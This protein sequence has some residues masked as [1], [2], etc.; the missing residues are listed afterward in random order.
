MALLLGVL[1]V[2]LMRTGGVGL[3]TVLGLA[4]G[5][6]VLA[7][8]GLVLGLW[9]LVHDSANRRRAVLAIILAMVVGFVPAR[10][11]VRGLDVPP[12]HDISTDLAE[13]PE[14]VTARTMRGPADHEVVNTITPE[15]AALQMEGYPDL[16][17][18]FISR[19]PGIVFDAALETLAD[20]ELKIIA[21]EPSRGSIEAVAI[22]PIM[23]F[24]DDVVVRVRE[25]DNGEAIVDIRSA[26]RQGESDLGTNARRIRDIF[27]ALTMRLGT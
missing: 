19:H 11:V 27:A 24:K 16:S 20:M 8:V 17:P 9:G 12:I 13:P 4:A 22:T 23:G 1:V 6:F 2:V 18:L 15:D 21:T 25:G 26:S 3:G 7:L 5:V 10:A 14:F